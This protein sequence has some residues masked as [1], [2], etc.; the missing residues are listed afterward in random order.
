MA[1]RGID[2]YA[3]FTV[4]TLLR[5][6][7]AIQVMRDMLQ[8]EKDPSCKT[9]P[10]LTKISGAS[11]LT[12]PCTGLVVPFNIAA[13]CE[14]P[15]GILT[16]SLPAAYPVLKDFGRRICDALS[17]AGQTFTRFTGYTNAPRGLRS[18][19]PFPSLGSNFAVREEQFAAETQ[20]VYYGASERSDSTGKLVDQKALKVPDKVHA[21]A[22][23][24]L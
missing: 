20:V 5:E 21:V 23:E 17:K 19:L 11:I 7:F 3:S 13:V 10:S 4:I 15:V 22:Q 12:D 18:F 2:C 9:T 6:I 24:V 1:D 14:Q 8:F 16:V